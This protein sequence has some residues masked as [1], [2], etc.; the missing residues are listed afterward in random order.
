MKSRYHVNTT[1]DNIVNNPVTIWFTCGYSD[2]YR[3]HYITT[4]TAYR[5]RYLSIL[6]SKFYVINIKGIVHP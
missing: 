4:D 2:G 6:L 1:Q 5:Y 3:L